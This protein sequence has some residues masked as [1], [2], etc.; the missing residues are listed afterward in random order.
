MWITGEQAISRSTFLVVPFFVAY[1]T[2]VEIA[3]LNY[4]PFIV[5]GPCSNCPAGGCGERGPRVAGGARRRVSI[6]LDLDG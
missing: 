6:E 2:D 5:G 1:L 3:A 4:S